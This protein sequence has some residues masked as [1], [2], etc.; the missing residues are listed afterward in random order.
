MAILIIL[1][2]GAAYAVI[3]GIITAVK[4]SHENRYCCTVD[5]TMEEEKPDIN[6]TERLQRYSQQVDGYTQLIKLL[7]TAYK[8]EK[9]TKRKAALLAKQLA[10]IDK[11][12]RTIAKLE[13]LDE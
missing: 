3:S 13:K 11:L 8:E 2:I 4:T 12:D 9:D 1:G 6:E 7:D 10:V 5:N